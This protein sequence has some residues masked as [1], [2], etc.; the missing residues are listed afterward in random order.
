MQVILL[1]NIGNLG[2]L[3]DTV[4]VKPGYGRNF[5]IPQG[6]AVPATKENVA[7]FEARRADLEKAAAEALAAAQARGEKLAEVGVVT[8]TANAGDEGKLFGSIGTRDIADAVTAAGCEID[9]SEVRLPEGA[10]RE[11]GEYVVAVQVHPEVMID[12]TLAVVP[13]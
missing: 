8:I 4:E 13:E 11:T 5:L 9:K 10:L 1:E 7:E 12:V 2:G 6:K 3:G